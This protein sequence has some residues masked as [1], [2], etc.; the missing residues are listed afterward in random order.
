MNAVPPASG[1]QP[2][3]H[4]SGSDDIDEVRRELKAAP[5]NENNW[6]RRA[7]LLYMWLSALQQQ[8][9]NL[10]PFMSVDQRYHPLEARL[11]GSASDERL[12]E[13]SALVDEGYGLM[14]AIQARLVNEGPIAQA[15]EGDAS[16]VPAGGDME[17]EWPMFQRDIHNSG[18]SEAPGPRHGRA[19]W[20]FP[21][22]LGWYARPVVEGGRVYVASPGMYT[23]S[24]CLDLATGDEIWKSTQE[25]PIFGIYKYPAIASTPLILGDRIVLR[26]VNSHWGNDSQSKYLHYIDKSSGELLARKFAGHVDYRTRYAPVASN[27]EVVVYPFAV[28]DIY[29]QPAICQNFNRL[30]CADLDNDQWLWDFNVG[31][32]DALA[33]PAVTRELAIVGTMEGYLYGLRLKAE[34]RDR[35][36]WQ[37][38]AA[39]SVNTQVALAG[40]RVYFGC[41]G[42]SLYCLDEFS[43]ALVWQTGVDPVESRANKHFS[44]PLIHGGRVYVG[45][46][47]KRFYAL[48]ADSGKRLWQIETSDWAR[49]RPVL[50]GEKVF[51]ATVDGKLHCLD[52]DGELAWSKAISAHPIYADVVLA[53]GNLLIGDSNLTLYCLSADGQ[54]VWEKSVLSAFVS[55]DCQRV[56][57]DEL[58]GGTYY[59]SKPTACR[60]K[61]YFGAPA[62]FLYAVDA[63]SGAEIWKFEM[64]G[65]HLCRTGLRR[66]TR[67]RRA[68]RRRTL[69]L[70]PRQ[71]RRLAVME[72]DLAGRLGL[73]LGG[74]RRR[75][76]LCAHRQRIRRLPGGGDGAYR[77]DVPDGALDPG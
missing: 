64:G 27:G 57:T 55:A 49:A 7:L 73:G 72:A 25:H 22:G 17:A 43:G 76:G 60:G 1:P 45:G 34:K 74:C 11:E 23:T 29:R 18:C 19:A 38:K 41:N 44:T 71:R 50:Q 35:I 66:G 36:A 32:I 56:F 48:E 30:I 65:G 6:R 24:Y 28:H 62:G 77:L 37:F 58:S 12:A 75:L 20:K 69:L 2:Q 31:D 46:A 67:L 16:A 3:F 52:R 59:Q 13:M 33:E 51:F 42:G 10:R 4:P 54:L 61:L 53:E 9:A 5:T 63:D 21:I 14:E 15:R 40:G 39:G 26:D 8:G 70:L 47:N 68:A